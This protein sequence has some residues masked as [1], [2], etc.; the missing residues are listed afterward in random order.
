MWPSAAVILPARCRA[1]DEPGIRREEVASTYPHGPDEATG[2]DLLA[3]WAGIRE[4][5]DGLIRLEKFGAALRREPLRCCPGEGVRRNGL[6]CHATRASITSAA[7][8]TL[9]LPTHDLAAGAAGC[10]RSNQSI[11]DAGHP[12]KSFVTNRG[13]NSLTFPWRD[14][15]RGD[16]HRI[17]GQIAAAARC[18]HDLVGHVHALGHEAK[19]RVVLGQLAG[20]VG[21]ADEKL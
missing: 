17:V 14:R 2:P 8:T 10:F 16:C 15:N 5:P 12:A 11:P 19:Q 13:E 18:R 6:F 9:T 1:R 7:P 4:P 21:D 3:F 20:Q